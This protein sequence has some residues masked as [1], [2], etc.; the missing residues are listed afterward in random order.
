[1]TAPNISTTERN[2]LIWV[3]D[4]LRAKR[5]RRLFGLLERPYINPLAFNMN[6]QCEQSPYAPCGTV[7]CIGGHM[8]LYLGLDQKAA[9]RFV[10][11]H[12]YH[13]SSPFRELFYGHL[14]AS[15]SLQFSSH[16]VS[17]KMAADAIDNFLTT[18]NPQWGDIIRAEV[19]K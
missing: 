18:G 7:A 3:R 4:G 14:K 19:G 2:A 10:E 16:E 6:N 13:Q 9:A 8:G 15:W 11:G 5:K 17:R 1:M 12:R